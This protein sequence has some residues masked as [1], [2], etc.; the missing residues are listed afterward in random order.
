[1]G[2]SGRSIL[3]RARLLLE[4]SLAGAL[5]CPVNVSS[6]RGALETKSSNPLSP[7]P[8]ETKT[9][10]TFSSDQRCLNSRSVAVSHR[11]AGDFSA[12]LL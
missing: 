10:T 9:A 5:A 8:A 1:L 11:R 3:H 6:F 12:L 7:M 4:A 2:A